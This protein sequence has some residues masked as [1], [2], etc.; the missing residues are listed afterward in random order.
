MKDVN[1]SSTQPVAI[2]G[3]GYVGIQLAIAFDRKVDVIGFDI[4]KRKIELFQ[5]GIDVTKEVGDEAIQQSGILYTSDS[6]VLKKAMTFIVA[7]PTPVD[8]NNEPDLGPL[9]SACEILGKFLKYESLVVFEST[10]YPGVTEEICIPILE[11]ESGL[12]AGNDFFIGYSPERLSPGDFHYTLD[13]VTKV[14]SGIN[15]ISQERIYKLYELIINSDMIYIAKSI[16]VAEAA[17]LIENTQRDINIAFMNECSIIFKN[18]NLN[19]HDVLDAASTKWN[20]FNA[21]PGL[22][23]GHC[24]GVDPYYLTYISKR[25]GYIPHLI[26]SSRSINEKMYIH[27]A[28]QLKLVLGFLENKKVLI[29]GITYKEDV[30]DIRNSKVASLVSKLSKLG[31]HIYVTDYMANT[32]DVFSEYGLTLYDEKDV[33][34]V[35]AIIFAV[36]HSNYYNTNLS[37]LRRKYTG[38]KLVLFDLYRIFDEQEVIQKD[39]LYWTL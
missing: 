2:I 32:E 17:K 38:S 33:F 25:N 22:V 20:F 8:K 14:I 35:D 21:Y 36:K 3:L 18:I 16:R 7:V 11:K 19:I 6:N 29:Y 1:F 23:G 30:S 10:V 15:S 5:Q 9:H 34:G 31:M 28:E 39:F 26:N 37:E 27:I 13:K 4:N 24:I 12:I